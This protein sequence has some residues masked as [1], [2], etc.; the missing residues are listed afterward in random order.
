MKGLSV[1]DV[2]PTREEAE[3]ALVNHAVQNNLNYDLEETPKSVAVLCKGRKEFGCEARIVAQL[4][5]KDGVFVVKR[6]RLSHKCP[7]VTSKYGSPEE[8][9]R[10]EVYR[11]I[12]DRYA[13]I[14]EV[15][16]ILAGMNIKMGY[17]SVWKAMRQENEMEKENMNL[18]PLEQGGKNEL[19]DAALK[20]FSHEFLELNPSA[21]SHCQEKMFFFSFPEYL[22]VLVPIVEI[23][24]YKRIE[25]FAVLGILRDPTWSPIIYSCVV[26]DLE[27]QESAFR[28]FIDSMPELFFLVD[29][30]ADLINVLKKKDRK[31]FVKTRDICKFYYNK[32]KSIDAVENI[33]NKCNNDR[34]WS[35][36]EL[37]FIDK[38][39]YLKR[40]CETEMLGLQNTSE[41]DVEFIGLGIFNLPFFDCI[42]A[43]LK[44]AS[45]NLKQRKKSPLGEG[46][47][48][49]GNNV[50]RRIEKNLSIDVTDAS[51]NVDLENQTC[52]C[53]RFQEFLI[54]CPHACKK[55]LDLGED[56]YSY[57][58]D[59]YSKA[60]LL[61]LKDI[62]PVVDLPVKCQSDRNLLKRGPG[63][64]KK[65]LVREPPVVRS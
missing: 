21:V 11:A 8:M 58:S 48:L 36:P 59:L 10:M 7:S 51:Y 62:T 61:K 34:E 24:I 55:I 26:S 28:Y 53:G 35:S 22:D 20:E 18:G 27:C 65:I 15:V 6:I 39:Q 52:T 44:L 2:F 12:G 56:P 14:G 49:F 47:Y 46:K 4:R 40:C 13:R 19:F 60:R 3:K 50:I 29:F 54:P 64:P 57:V 23:R 1:N 17:F 37:S 30:D 63:R 38:K 43:I 42:G 45:D 25:G 33:W 41:C 5:K 9:V 32:T 16:S 31:F